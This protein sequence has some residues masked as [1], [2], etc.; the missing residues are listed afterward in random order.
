MESV[1][2][3]I[4]PVEPRIAN[5]FTTVIFSECCGLVL[6]DVFGEGVPTPVIWCKVF[7]LFGL[8]LHF[9]LVVLVKY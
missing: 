7:Y 2:C 1:L 6:R 8:G 4:E 9:V 3:P 5:F